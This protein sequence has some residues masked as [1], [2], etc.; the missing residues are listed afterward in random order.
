MGSSDFFMGLVWKV[1]IQFRWHK[2]IAVNGLCGHH[3]IES[4]TN[5]H[6]IWPQFREFHNATGRNVDFYKFNKIKSIFPFGWSEQ[7]T[8]TVAQKLIHFNFKL[9]FL[10]RRVFALPLPGCGAFSFE[11]PLWHLKSGG[12]ER[13]AFV[14]NLI[15]GCMVF[16]FITQIENNVFVRVVR[17]EQKWP[18]LKAPSD[19]RNAQLKKWKQRTRCVRCMAYSCGGGAAAAWYILMYYRY[20]VRFEL[21]F[22]CCVSFA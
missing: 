21:C 20:C 15:T 9:N 18:S 13:G 17:V 4:R 16:C 11:F 6:R 22:N 8:F 12:R 14:I 7:F 2:L 1:S 10:F 5:G 19:I 3:W